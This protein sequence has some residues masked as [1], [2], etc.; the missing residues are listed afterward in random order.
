M[1]RENKFNKLI[2]WQHVGVL[3][4]LCCITLDAFAITPTAEIKTI[5]EK[6]IDYAATNSTYLGMLGAGLAGTIMAF[7]SEVKKVIGNNLG[8]VGYV[9]FVGTAVTGALTVLGMTI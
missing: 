1:N 9:A 2:T 3:L 5:K 6:I 4:T 8:Y 7:G